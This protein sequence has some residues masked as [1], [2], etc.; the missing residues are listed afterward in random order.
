MKVFQAH[1]SMCVNILVASIL[2]ILASSSASTINNVPHNNLDSNSVQR[3]IKFTNKNDVR[4][5]KAEGS[6]CYNIAY[7]VCECTHTMCTAD[8]CKATGGMWVDHCPESCSCNSLRALNNSPAPSSKPTSSPTKRSGSGT[9]KGVGGGNR[10]GM[11]GGNQE[12]RNPTT[13]NTSDS[14]SYFD[15]GHSFTCKSWMTV[16]FF[17]ISFVLLH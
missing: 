12:G 8:L 4:Y 6:A 5:L 13:N 14:S 9:G 10:D 15:F 2:L 3:A 11:G 1:A 7:Q 16:Y 17:F